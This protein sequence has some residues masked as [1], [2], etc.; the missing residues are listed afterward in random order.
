MKNQSK[1]ST[2]VSCSGN[3]SRRNFL[4]ATSLLAAAAFSGPVF[5]ASG[6]ERQKYDVCIYG[7][8]SGGVMAAATLARLGRSVVLIEPTRHVGGMT[9]AGLGWVDF[10]RAS[11]IGGAT[12]KYFDS[13]RAYYAG[14]NIKTNGWSVEPHVAELLF[15]RMLT[16]NR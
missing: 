4:Q 5:A 11:S 13:I 3:I 12:K 6:A 1:Q 8:T 14:E 9:A 10:G 2:F 16:E 15:E 7:A